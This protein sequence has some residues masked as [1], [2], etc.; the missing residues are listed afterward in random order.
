VK[1]DNAPFLYDE[2]WNPPEVKKK[3]KQE[4]EETSPA[5]SSDDPQPELFGL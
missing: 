1:F 3:K 2:A 4:P 5:L